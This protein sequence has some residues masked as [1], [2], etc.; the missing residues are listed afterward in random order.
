MQGVWLVVSDIMAVPK[1]APLLSI[2]ALVLIG[3]AIGLL[4]STSRII[5]SQVNKVDYC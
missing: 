4:A 2:L 1:T 5:A 3:V